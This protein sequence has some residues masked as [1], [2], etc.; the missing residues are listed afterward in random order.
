MP[1]HLAKSFSPC[2]ALLGS[3]AGLATDAAGAVVT[4]TFGPDF[5]VEGAVCF[6]TLFS[7]AAAVELSGADE[8]EAEAGGSV[9]RLVLGGS[10]CG[11]VSENFTACESCGKGME[12]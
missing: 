2:S 5:N 3:E 7:R 1:Y 10:S 4:A 8:D 9:G 6:S 12:G 11:S